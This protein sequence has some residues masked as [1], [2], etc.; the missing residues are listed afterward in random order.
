MF[1][2]RRWM[3]RRSLVMRSRPFAAIGRRQ[4]VA[5]ATAAVLRP[6]TARAYSVFFG[7]WFLRGSTTINARGREVLAPAFYRR[8]AL[9]G[10]RD[11][12]QFGV[13][14]SEPRPWVHVGG[15]GADG[16]H[17]AKIEFLTS[18]RTLNAVEV[19]LDAGL[20]R[21]VI[22]ASSYGNRRGLFGSLPMDGRLVQEGADSGPGIPAEIMFARFRAKIAT[23]RAAHQPWSLLRLPKPIW[24]K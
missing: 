6:R 5:L 16:A 8:H 24:K 13:W 2:R 20:P 18:M 23:L 1:C 9:N 17:A 12:A 21:E 22:V 15:F 3:R 11:L 10:Y 7:A 19:L 14:P 4:A